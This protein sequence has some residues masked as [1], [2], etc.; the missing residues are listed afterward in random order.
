[1][2]TPSAVNFDQDMQTIRDY[3]DP[4]VQAQTR[5]AAAYSAALDSFQLT[6]QRPR[7]PRPGPT[8]L[9]WCLRRE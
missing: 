3:V 9:A 2:A 8:S 7:R 5:V 6:V 4:V 1:M